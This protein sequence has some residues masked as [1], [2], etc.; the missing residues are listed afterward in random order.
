MCYYTFLNEK[1]RA[2]VLLFFDICKRARI[3]VQFFCIYKIFFVLLVA[4]V[5][6]KK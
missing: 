2:K 4:P 5:D 1:L 3:F 6:L